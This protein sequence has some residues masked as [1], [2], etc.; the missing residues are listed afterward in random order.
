MLDRARTQTSGDRRRGAVAAFAADEDGTVTIF[1]LIIFIL[2]VWVGGIA[3]DVMRYEAQ[4]TTLQATLDRAVLAAASLSQPFEPEDVVLDYFAAAQLGDYRLRVQ[5]E[6]GLNFRRVGAAAESDIDT[7]FMRLMNIDTL[8]TPANGT[9]EERITNIEI[10][11]VLDISGSMG[12]QSA[13]PGQSKIE[14]LRQAAREFVTTVL[15]GFED[16]EDLVSISIIPYNG[17]VN[18]GSDLAG[19]WNLTNEHSQSNCSRFYYDDFL[20]VALDPSQPLQ[21]MAHFSRYNEFWGYSNYEWSNPIQTPHCQTSEYGA[22]LP[23]QSDETVLH[24]HINSLN[25]D[26][27]TAIDSGMRWAVALLDPSTNPALEGLADAGTVPEVFRGRPAAHDDDETMK[28]VVLMTDGANTNQYDIHDNRRSGPS[29]IWYSADNNDYSVYF[30][31]WDQWW[32]YDSNT[33][34]DSPDGSD[35]V[36]LDFAEVWS[37]FSVRAMAEHMYPVRAYSGSEWW[38]QSEVDEDYYYY[39]ASINQYA[40]D[41]E[42]DARLS[43]ICDATRETDVLVYAVAFEAPPAGETALQY[44]ATQPAYYYDVAGTEISEAFASIARSINGL[45]L[46]Q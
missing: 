11:L 32:H 19:V 10:S 12:A 29:P 1:G 8:T 15:D 5:S 21:R 36:Q 41:S 27:W 4:R 45:R 25:A 13:N 40:W 35:A 42:G 37:R 26:G 33:W 7:M 46:V 38:R 31:E 28:V 18:M 17:R 30:D 23:W 39:R 20:Q 3:I 34:R 6:E 22:I 24:N 43:A 16:D 14:A 9:A 2:M 44:C